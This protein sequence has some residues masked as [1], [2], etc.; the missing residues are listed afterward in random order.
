MTVQQMCK[1]SGLTVDTIRYYERIGLVEVEKDAYFKNYN[2]QILET[3]I[4]IKKLRLT[5]LS[6][7][8]IKLLLSIDDTPT[9][10]SQKQID[11]VSTVINNAI[12]RTRIRAKE[13][14]ESQQLLKN[15][16]RKLI[17]VRNENK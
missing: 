16:E 10:L 13:I 14:A 7:R 2:Q 1:Q 5:G 17:E 4:A 9:E 3:L 6:L 11:S 15:M 8:E 12:E